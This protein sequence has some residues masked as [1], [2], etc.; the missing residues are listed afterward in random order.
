VVPNPIAT[1]DTRKLVQAARKGV[2]KMFKPDIRYAK[3][4]IMLFDISPGESVQDDLFGLGDSTGSHRLMQT[5]DTINQHY[6]SHTV[7]FASEGIH[8][9]WAMK[10][11]LMTQAFTTQW[12]EIPLVC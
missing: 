6:G 4:G 7:F 5:I 12:S 1:S 11:N 3:A 10:R 2:E 9:S 8:K